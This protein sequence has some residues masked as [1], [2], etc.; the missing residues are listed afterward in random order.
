[1]KLTKKALKN[2][3]ELTKL[4]FE[5]KFANV[6]KMDSDGAF[7]TIDL[8]DRRVD[9]FLGVPTAENTEFIKEITKKLKD[10]G[11]AELS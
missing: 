8:D 7:V 10:E 4:G 5:R 1:M 6:Y 2:P 9:I 3:D 11:L